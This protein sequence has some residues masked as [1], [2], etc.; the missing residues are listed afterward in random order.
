MSTNVGKNSAEAFIYRDET[1]L[2]LSDSSGRKGE[3]MT[4]PLLIVVDNPEREGPMKI[5][6]IMHV[7]LDGVALISSFNGLR[8]GRINIHNM[9]PG[10]Y[11]LYAGIDEFGVVPNY[12]K[13]TQKTVMS[14]KTSGTNPMVYIFIIMFVLVIVIALLTF[15]VVRKGSSELI[16]NHI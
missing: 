6:Q 7:P 14:T 8:N 13:A 1:G 2:Y 9:P 10:G 15:L 12:Q 11:R 3:K 5:Q 16:A 4:G